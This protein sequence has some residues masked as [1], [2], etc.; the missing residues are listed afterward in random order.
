MT[1]GRAATENDGVHAAGGVL[2]VV[3][4]L[5]AAV[6][7]AVNAAAGRTVSPSFWFMQVAVAVAYGVLALALRRAAT[8]ALRWTVT[9]IA[10]GAAVSVLASEW[11]LAQP[12]TWATWLGS[13][14]WAPGYVAILTLLPAL[15]PDGRVP[16]SRWRALPALA[17][18]VV[19]LT[20][21]AWA[22]APYDAQD[23]PEPYAA[24][25]NPFGLDV[26]RESAVWVGLGVLIVGTVLLGFAS[27]VARWRGATG[28]PRQQ[29]KWVLLGVAGTLLLV[30]VSRLAPLTWQEGLAS[31]AMVPMP[32]AIGVAVLRHGLWDVEVVLSRSLVYVLVSAVSVAAY[33]GLVGLVDLLGDGD[34]SLLAVAVLAPLVLPLH[35]ALQRRV[36]RWVHGGE[37]EPWE[38]LHRLGDQLAAATDP[39]D[40]AERVLPSVL[41]RVR[42]AL[43]ADGARLRLSDGTVLV[44][45]S[46]PDGGELLPL[47]YGGERLG[48]L[49]VARPGGFG[50]LER[51]QLGRLATQVAV[52]VHA[53]LLAR[54]SRRARELVVVAREEERRRLRRDLHDGVGP[55]VAALALQV[56]TARDLAVEDPA[57]ATALLDRLAPR[58]NAVVADVRA[59]VHELRPPTLDE[60]GLAA[61]VRELGA[62]LGGATHVE[63]SCGELGELPAAVEVA[64]Y[65]IAGEGI[66]NAARHSGARSVR[67]DLRRDGDELLL[68]VSD[69]GAG[70]DRS[71][72][73]G[74]GLGLSSMRARSEELGGTFSVVSDPS[75]TTLRARLPLTDTDTGAAAAPRPEG[76]SA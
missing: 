9:G 4:A 12:S 13:W 14:S 7:H 67:V 23:F 73:N 29:L 49:E 44:D 46:A 72:S 41:A 57:A 8:P 21:L 71:G 55:S 62:R 40:L 17:V 45:G 43:R 36:N 56:E 11:A 15:L 27:L 6:L 76:A 58:I 39:D 10:V 22:V 38:E 47:E 64:A 31:L 34:V 53:V 2:A 16:S 65:R 74:T 66:A 18:V 42:R 54:E 3:G 26:M 33:V 5:V 69:D 70:I 30:V 60:L 37:D 50:R 52:A 51:D 35:S 32:A 28:V 1:P 68:T 75:G 19:A 48:D 63:V 25:R 61:A 20:G 59:L 24:S